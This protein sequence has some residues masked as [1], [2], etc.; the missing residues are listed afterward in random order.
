MSGHME[1]RHELVARFPAKP[2]QGVL[3]VSMEFASAMHYCMCG[4]GE[5]V[6]TPLTPTDWRVIY[7]GETMSLA[8]S[9]GNWSMQC[10]S[11]YWLDCGRVRWAARW[12][13]EKIAAGRAHDRLA[14][15]R[16]FGEAP[17]VE[18]RPDVADDPRRGWQ[19]RLLERLRNRRG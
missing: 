10:Q 9:V 18:L 14:K 12:T 4:C 11:H 2:D 19:F 6:I 7:D 17:V 5:H 16:Q 3:Y 1:Y 8:P 13:P 15:A